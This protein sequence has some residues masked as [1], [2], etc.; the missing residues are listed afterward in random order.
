[1]D[2][3][4]LRR[5]GLDYREFAAVRIYP[6]LEKYLLEHCKKKVF[7]VSTK[8]KAHY[9]S[10]SY[11]PGDTFIFGPESRGLP[12]TLRQRFETIRI[13]MLQHSRS[14]NL[15]NAVSIIMYEAIRQSGFEGID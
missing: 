12:K 6:D 7:A 5:A 13:P 4:Q 8:G 1:M 2:D 10:H 9:D 14:L 3:K 15:S 11:K